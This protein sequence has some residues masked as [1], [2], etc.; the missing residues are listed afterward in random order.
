MS[1]GVFGSGGGLELADAL[2]TELLGSVPPDGA[3]RQAGDD[4]RPVVLADPGA[5]SAQ[6][7]VDIAARIAATA[8]ERGLGHVVRPLP[9]VS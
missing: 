1:G 3:L 7:I 5:E 2:R 6:A 4:G 8:R 9:I